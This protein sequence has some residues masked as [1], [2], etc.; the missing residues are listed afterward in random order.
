MHVELWKIVVFVA[1]WTENIFGHEVNSNE[2][3]NKEISKDDVV[4]KESIA[5]E[6][7]GTILQLKGIYYTTG[8]RSRIFV[9]YAN[10]DDVLRFGKKNDV[11]ENSSNENEDS[12][13]Q[14]WSILWYIG[15]FGG[16]I[17][18]F[19]VVS[20]SEWCCRTRLRGR[21]SQTT[22]SNS[23][24]P[25]DVPPP[26]YDLFAPPS[27]ESLCRPN[28]E[29]G[30]YDVYVVP[31]HTLRSISEAQGTADNVLDSPPSYS[32]QTSNEVVLNVRLHEELQVVPKSD[33]QSS[34][35]A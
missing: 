13:F 4:V 12:N 7:D 5:L 8:P 28:G 17:A 35:R 22:S 6:P 18:F 24:N 23:P 32:V 15:S 31:V 9:D 33:N 26:A 3:P 16:L 11:D 25:N 20:C 1:L 2:K 34:S 30:E 19:L 14:P 27:Y 29:K 21:N 10:Q